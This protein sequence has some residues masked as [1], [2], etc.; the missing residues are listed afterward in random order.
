MSLQRGQIHFLALAEQLTGDRDFSSEKLTPSP[1][2]C[3]LCMHMPCKLHADRQPS[4]YMKGNKILKS[5]IMILYMHISQIYHLI[6]IKTS[7]VIIFFF[8]DRV[9]LKSP[10][11]PAS[12]S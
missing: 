12:V 2:L 7:V 5:H 11:R 8:G 6:S 9:S 1:G 4:I 10:G 3:S